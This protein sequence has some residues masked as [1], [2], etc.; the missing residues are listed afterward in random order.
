[1]NSREKLIPLISAA[2]LGAVLNTHFDI[3]KYISLV[4]IGVAVFLSIYIGSEYFV[5][6]K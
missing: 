2:L 5:K 6:S 4:L 1:M 3:L